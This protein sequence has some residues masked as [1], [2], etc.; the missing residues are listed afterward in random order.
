MFGPR[1]DVAKVYLDLKGILYRCKRCIR[2]CDAN[3]VLLKYVVWLDIGFVAGY[4]VY[5]RNRNLVESFLRLH[6][7]NLS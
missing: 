3:V 7:L 4:N 1:D 2:T 6:R 5:V